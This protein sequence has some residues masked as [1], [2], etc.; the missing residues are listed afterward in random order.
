MLS[1]GGW[2]N[3]IIVGRET[4]MTELDLPAST[5]T[6][7]TKQE[8]SQFVRGDIRALAAASLS[9]RHV[10][11]CHGRRR[12]PQRSIQSSIAFER[13]LSGKPKIDGGSSF[14]GWPLKTPI[15]RSA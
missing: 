12:G 3:P 1:I 11:G 14:I 7:R 2:G 15:G 6:D 10:P 13:E 9:E 5:I 4:A 8:P